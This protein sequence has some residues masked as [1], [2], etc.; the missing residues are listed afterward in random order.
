MDLNPTTSKTT[1]TIQTNFFNKKNVH[2][3]VIKK[4]D[5]SRTMIQIHR[6]QHP[7]MNLDRQVKP[8]R[9]VTLLT[10]NHHFFLSHQIAYQL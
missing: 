4:I 1:S 8:L 7:I 9:F 3:L 6:P 2:P 10:K 5:F